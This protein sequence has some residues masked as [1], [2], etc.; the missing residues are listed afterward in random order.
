MPGKVGGFTSMLFHEVF[1][2]L[3][4]VEAAFF[5]PLQSRSQGADSLFYGKTA[6]P[7]QCDFGGFQ[8]A[9]LGFDFL[10]VGCG[11]IHAVFFLYL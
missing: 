2:K 5:H 11:D 8:L 4:N 10:D 3:L 7:V 6:I 1:G 9:E